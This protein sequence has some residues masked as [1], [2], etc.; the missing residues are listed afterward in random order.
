MNKK[1]ALAV[2]TAL[3]LLVGLAACSED[4][5]TATSQPTA[6]PTPTTETESETDWEEV[7][8]PAPDP[9]VLTGDAY[10]KML[11]PGPSPYEDQLYYSYRETDSELTELVL[12]EDGVIDLRFIFESREVSRSI[13]RAY[14]TDEKGS[15]EAKAA[16]TCVQPAAALPQAFDCKAHFT[17][18]GNPGGTYYGVIETTPIRTED[19]AYGGSDPAVPITILPFG[20]E[21][22]LCEE[23]DGEMKCNSLPR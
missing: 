1:P 23:I 21:G 9:D 12:A 2:M 18:P 6:T 4:P 14:V 20:S 7:P 16:L 3:T 22:D 11:A 10:F 15:K 13:K 5:G 8:L 17:V 19:A